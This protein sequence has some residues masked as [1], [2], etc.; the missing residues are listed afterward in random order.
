MKIHRIQKRDEVSSASLIFSKNENVLF[1]ILTKNERVKFLCTTSL[2][3][4]SSASHIFKSVD[5]LH[6]ENTPIFSL[7]CLKSNKK[8]PL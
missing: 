3:K 1:C 6:L 7:R 4:A 5:N 2:E 8:P